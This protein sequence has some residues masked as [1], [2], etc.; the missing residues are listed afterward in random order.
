MLILTI[1]PV[2]DS[3]IE[4]PDFSLAGRVKRE[5]SFGLNILPWRPENHK[6]AIQVRYPNPEYLTALGL[7]GNVTWYP[8]F[9]LRLTCKRL[10][11]HQNPDVYAN[12]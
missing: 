11:I 6:G 10:A 1:Q 2:E 9:C 12:A 7:F 5:N 8:G 3:D 4:Y